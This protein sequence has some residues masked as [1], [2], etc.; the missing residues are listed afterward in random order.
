LRDRV[1]RATQALA[2][3]FADRIALHP[4]DWHMLQ[5][6]WLAD[7]DQDRLQAS[8]PVPDQA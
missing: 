2:D 6:L 3:V 4:A 7:L 8:V 1:Q 5:P